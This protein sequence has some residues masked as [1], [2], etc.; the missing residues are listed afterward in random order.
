V[1]IRYHP[2]DTHWPGPALL[3]GHIEWMENPLQSRGDGHIASLDFPES[4]TS[5]PSM[6]WAYACPRLTVLQSF[7]QLPQ[8]LLLRGHLFIGTLPV[9]DL[10]KSQDLTICLLPA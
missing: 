1:G 9:Q 2:K 7:S 3:A 10:P 8:H 6:N 4:G 5:R